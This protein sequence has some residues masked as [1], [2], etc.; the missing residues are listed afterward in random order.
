MNYDQNNL[1]Y[2]INR[3]LKEERFLEEDNFLPSEISSHIDL[4]LEKNTTNVDFR[5]YC[6]TPK[7]F[8]NLNEYFQCYQLIASEKV[9]V[10]ILE[11]LLAFGAALVNGFNIFCLFLGSQKRT[12]F[13]EILVGYCLVNGVT[14]LIDIPFFHVSDIFGYWPFGKTSAIIWSV[15]DNNINY[16]TAAHMFYASYA[17]FR[18]LKNPYGYNRE[19]LLIKPFLVMGLI[20]IISLGIWGIIMAT[21]GVKP[22]SLIVDFNP[23]YLESILNAPWLFFIIGVLVLAIMILIFLFEKAAK[24]KKTKPRKISHVSTVEIKSSI[25]ADQQSIA[26][27]FS[28]IKIIKL[29]EFFRRIHPEKKFLIIMGSYWVQWAP[30]CIMVMISPFVNI[31]ATI[32]HGIY[33]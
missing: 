4:N 6:Y 1:F 26:G 22:Y 12:C 32:Y 2:L 28:I 25:A 30:P 3:K 21:V 5:T 27:S 15:Y 23:F 14:G 33:W 18:S 17:R 19:L 11:L 31:D 20:W 16:N 8:T 29:C 24:I 9:V 7:T 10:L 13:D